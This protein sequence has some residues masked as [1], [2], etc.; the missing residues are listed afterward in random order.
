MA[1][2]DN[3]VLL[4]FLVICALFFPPL[5]VFLKDACGIHFWLNILLTICGFFPGLL[6]ALWVI[7]FYEPNNISH[8]HIVHTHG[9]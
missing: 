3:C 4:L 5:P 2:D 1:A 9:Y 7:L 6:H 8:V